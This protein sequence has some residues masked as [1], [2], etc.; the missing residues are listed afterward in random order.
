MV[1]RK[2]PINNAIGGLTIG[3]KQNSIAAPKKT[4]PQMGLI[5]P[6]SKI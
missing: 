5:L 1:A 2:I 6:I 3:D 4:F